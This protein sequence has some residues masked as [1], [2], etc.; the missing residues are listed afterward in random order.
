MFLVHVLKLNGYR[1]LAL[2]GDTDAYCSLMGTRR[3]IK[4]LG[5]P[6]TRAWEPWT[7]ND[8][9]FGFSISYGPFTLRTIHGH[10]HGAIYETAPVASR[11][12]LD[13]IAAAQH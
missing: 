11:T 5:W 7:I 8:Q 12:I 4:A 2:F 13:F 6:V 9:L 3:W 10:G 1:M